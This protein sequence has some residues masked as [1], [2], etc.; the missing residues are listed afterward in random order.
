MRRLILCAVLV[1]CW[2]G[3]VEG[4]IT[5]GVID[6]KYDLNDRTHSSATLFADDSGMLAGIIRGLVEL[7]C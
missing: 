4:G 2:G 1:F 6:L 5:V 3:Q 7:S